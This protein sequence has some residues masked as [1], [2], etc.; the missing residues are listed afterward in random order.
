MS[1]AI[2]GGN[3]MAAITGGVFITTPLARTVVGSSLLEA[4]PSSIL[5]AYIINT[6]DKMSWSIEKDNWPL[7]V[8]S[9]PDGDNVENDCG[10]IYDTAGVL[11]GRQMD[12]KVPQHQGLQLRIRSQSYEVGYAKAEDIALELDEVANVSLTIDA[13]EYEIQNVSRTTPIVFLG[14]EVGTK[15]RYLFTVNFLLTIRKLD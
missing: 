3:L 6:L 1:N 9:M 12:G 5:A 13:G 11:D 7:F 4:S 10:A 2:V 15:R 14:P 8:S